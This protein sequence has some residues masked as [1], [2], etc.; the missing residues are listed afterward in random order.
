VRE[1][2]RFLLGRASDQGFQVVKIQPRAKAFPA[3]VKIKMRAEDLLT[4]SSARIRSSNQFVADGVALVGRLRV[5]VATAESSV[6]VSV[7]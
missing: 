3:P 1:S 7:L 2:F 6:S 5:M 4:S